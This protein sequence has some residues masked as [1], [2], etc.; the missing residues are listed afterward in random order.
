MDVLNVFKCCIE[1]LVSSWCNGTLLITFVRKNIFLYEFSRSLST[2]HH[3]YY[4]ISFICR[5]QFVYLVLQLH[6][7]Y[8]YII[9]S[10]DA[11]I[12]FISKM[13][14]KHTYTQ[15]LYTRNVCLCIT[16][17]SIYHLHTDDDRMLYFFFHALLCLFF[18][19]SFM[20]RPPSSTI[21]EDATAAAETAP[22]SVLR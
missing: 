1:G 11:L 16:S 12:F 13:Y 14:C 22:C 18:V 4:C 17:Y 19:S 5:Y 8:Y 7:S 21:S 20:E 9:C 10:G 6:Y 15:E 2:L 3:Y